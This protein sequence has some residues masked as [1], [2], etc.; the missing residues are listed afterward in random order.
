MTEVLGYM[1]SLGDRRLMG[2]SIRVALVVGTVL[3]VLNHG[4]AIATR[5][6][7]PDR[8]LSAGLTYL[9]PYSVSIHGQYAARR[10]D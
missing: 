5:T 7:T 4:K 6:M 2:T 3:V 9:V 8:W 1:R 10:R